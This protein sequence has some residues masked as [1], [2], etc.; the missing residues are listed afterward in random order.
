MKNLSLTLRIKNSSETLD[1]TGQ[2]TKL[3]RTIAALRRLEKQRQRLHAAHKAGKYAVYSEYHGIDEPI[4]TKMDGAVRD[5]L[6]SLGSR[7]I[8]IIYDDNGDLLSSL[9]V[10]LEALDENKQELWL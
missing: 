5:N 9:E 10:I 6:G 1:F 8:T 4:Y 2:K 3:R 7:L